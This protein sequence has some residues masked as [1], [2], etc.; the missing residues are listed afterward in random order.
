MNVSIDSID[1]CYFPII[2]SGGKYDIKISAQ[3]NS[4][5]LSS[6]IIICSLGA[7]YKGYCANMAR[8]FMVNV[9]NKVESIYTVLLSLYDACLEK[10]IPGNELKDVYLAAK[11]FLNKT[12]SKL[13][14]YLPKSLGF[15]IGLEFRDNLLVL[16]EK[17]ETKFVDGMIFTLAV[18][19]HNIPLTAEEKGSLQQ[20]DVFSLLMADTVRILKDAVP[21][22]L[23]K[24]S[25]DFSDV[26][27]TISEAEV[28]TILFSFA[29]SI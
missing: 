22:I 20:L 5:A 8:T 6:D 18:G 11:A 1:A 24:T 17:N 12:D 15:A 21:E 29:Y 4:D 7:K 26:S 28:R 9:P 16:N 23:T 2:Q 25:K 19:F 13:L 14:A 27:Y 10:M 3:S